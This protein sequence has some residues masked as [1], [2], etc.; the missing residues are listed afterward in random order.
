MANVLKKDI[1]NATKKW[2]PKGA[3]LHEALVAAKKAGFRKFSS[4]SVTKEAAT[5]YFKGLQEK[6]LLKSHVGPDGVATYSASAKR[7]TDEARSQKKTSAVEERE[8]HLADKQAKLEKAGLKVEK[9]GGPETK[10][11]L[12]AGVAPDNMALALD[13][14]GMEELG[15][16][17]P[18]EDMSTTS[19]YKKGVDASVSA[20]DYKTAGQK[21]AEQM[22]LAPTF[23]MPSHE[24][25]KPNSNI[26]L[27]P[28]VAPLPQAKPTE[29]PAAEPETKAEST[30]AAPE[31]E[32][33]D[34]SQ[35]IDL[36][37]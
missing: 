26:E 25:P 21:A 16:G 30:H 6:H 23:S 20:K 8:A 14:S 5:R 1:F 29:A 33:G 11:E 7:L 13:K 36:P 27:A 12:L 18:G 22:G 32:P 10:E 2:A 19:G 3:D 34:E 9:I 15:L 17:L 28:S 35:A 31:Q 24:A 4:G 37:I